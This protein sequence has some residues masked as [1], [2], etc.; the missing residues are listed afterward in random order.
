[1]KSPKWCT[2]RHTHNI[3]FLPLDYLYSHGQKECIYWQITVW[4]YDNHLKKMFKI[5]KLKWERPKITP[6]LHRVIW[7]QCKC[8]SEC[9]R[10]SGRPEMLSRRPENGSGEGQYAEKMDQRKKLWTLTYL[11]WKIE[12]VTCGHRP[13]GLVHGSV[14]NRVFLVKCMWLCNLLRWLVDR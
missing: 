4:H 2:H 5:I 8:E 7:N 1:M 14:C 3:I 10:G 13:K 11:T 6:F 9:V 12:F